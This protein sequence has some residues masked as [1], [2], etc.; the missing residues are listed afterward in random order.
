MFESREGIGSE[1]VA[2]MKV[3]AAHRVFLLLTHIDRKRYKM[4]KLSCDGTFEH[5]C[6]PGSLD[7]RGVD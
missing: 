4:I 3:W 6:M 7:T 5:I 2:K 1:Y